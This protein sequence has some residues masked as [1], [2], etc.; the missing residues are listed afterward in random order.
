MSKQQQQQQHPL[1]PLHPSKRPVA[2]PPPALHPKNNHLL[3][4]SDPRHPRHGI[5]LKRDRPHGLSA[6]PIP[7]NRPM[8]P[9]I[10][11][12]RHYFRLDNYINIATFDP[13]NKVYRLGTVYYLEFYRT[14]LTEGEYYIHVVRSFFGPMFD[15][16]H[17]MKGCRPVCFN[18][19]TF[20]WL[21]GKQTT[22]LELTEEEAEEHLNWYQTEDPITKAN[23]KLIIGK[24]DPHNVYLTHMEIAFCVSLLTTFNQYHTRVFVAGRN[25]NGCMVSYYL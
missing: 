19:Y 25:M 15:D 5:W 16:F 6:N 8:Y 1:P 7:V 10:P 23:K 18:I 17:S 14:T 11:M 20:D 12:L 21:P 13:V 22:K 2:V 3:P 4:L 9:Y 24:I